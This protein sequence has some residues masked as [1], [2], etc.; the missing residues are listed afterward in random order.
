LKEDTRAL[1]IVKLSPPDFGYDRLVRVLE[2]EPLR[3]Q[4]WNDAESEHEPGTSYMVALVAGVPAAWAGWRIQPDG[5]LRCCNNY[6][7]HG[8]RD[9]NPELYASAYAARHRDVVLRLNV[10]AVTYLYP[11]PTP[12]HV[13]DG[14]TP[15]PSPD[16]SGT[17]RPFEGGPLHHWQRLT[18]SPPA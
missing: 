16:S 11:E 14:W 17:S 3:T 15:D 5:T 8:Y 7:R 1:R 9:R 10:P 12:L 2:S 4:W 6:V 13:A 18:W